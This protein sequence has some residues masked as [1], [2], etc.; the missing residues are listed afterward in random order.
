MSLQCQFRRQTSAHCKSRSPLANRASRSVCCSVCAHIPHI[1]DKSRCHLSIQLPEVD[2]LEI[3][4]LSCELLLS[5]TNSRLDA[6]LDHP[7]IYFSRDTLNSLGFAAMTPVQ[8]AVLPLFMNQH[9]DVV[10]QAVTGS[11][12]TLAF[13]I[14]LLE[15]LLRKEEP[16]RADQVGGIILCPTRYVKM[17]RPSLPASLT[18]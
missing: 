14:P 4:L 15:K 18:C 9:K 12:K 3:L 13:V 17:A 7:P 10:V 2:G 6:D 8:A 16:L 5:Y 1:Q 11:G